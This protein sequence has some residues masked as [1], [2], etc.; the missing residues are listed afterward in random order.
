LKQDKNTRL[1]CCFFL[2]GSSHPSPPPTSPTSP[3]EVIE[4]ERGDDS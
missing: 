3:L 2:F 4:E 1:F